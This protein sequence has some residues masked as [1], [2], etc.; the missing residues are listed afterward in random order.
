MSIIMTVL[1]EEPH[2]AHAVRSVLSQDYPGE[3]EVVVAVGPSR[4]RTRE[5]AERLAAD[6]PRVVVVDN[7]SG[8]TPDGLNAAVGASRHDVVVR[9]DGHGELS[10]GYVRRAVELLEQTGAANVGGIMLAEG[11]GPVQET[12][13]LAMRSPLGM[14]SERFHTGGA[15]GPADTVF[16]GVFRRAWLERVGGYDP[17]YTRAQ[18]W[19][20]NHRIRAAG[21]TIW[22]TPEL[23]V[24]YR[25]R[26]TFRALARQFYTSGQWRRQVVRQ[27]PDSVNARYL[28]PPV[29]LCAVAAGAVG[30]LAWRPL[31]V[32]PLG[33][34]AAV[35]L[36]GAWIA[37]GRGAGVVAR[38]PAVLATMHLTWGAGFLRGPRA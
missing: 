28:A 35:T 37:R 5:V 12:V 21:G 10:E 13:A 24:T 18:D 6:D 9:M 38:M 32:L 20:L 22:F 7:P 11:S 34:A 33:Y 29:A 14:G 4:D 8:R 30:G 17:A 19:E 3:M 1:D 16:L 25:P 36:G 26:S 15:E 27:H 2:L 23:T 31:W